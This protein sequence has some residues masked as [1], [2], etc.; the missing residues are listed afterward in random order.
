MEGHQRVL[1]VTIQTT[2]PRRQPSTEADKDGVFVQQVVE[3]FGFTLVSP[4]ISHTGLDDH[5]VSAWM[6]EFFVEC[7]GRDASRIKYISFHDYGGS[8]RKLLSRADGLMKRYGKP[9]WL[10]EFTIS[11]WVRVHGDVCDNCHITR[12]MQDA[13]M[14]EALPSLDRSSAVHRYV[15]YSAREGS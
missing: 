13:Y 15:W 3:R 8:V 6:D 11:K 10:T 4:D 5:G 2:G 12:S 1:S 7:D 14:K 9:T